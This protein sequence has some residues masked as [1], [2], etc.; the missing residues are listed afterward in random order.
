MK[1]NVPK[2][3]AFAKHLRKD[4]PNAEYKL[5]QGLRG[6]QLAGQHFRRQH[7][8]GPYVTDFTCVKERLVVEVDGFGHVTE[9]KKLRDEKWTEYLQAQEWRVIRFNN[10]DVFEDVENDL[11]AIAGHLSTATEA[12]RING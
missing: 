12:E 3:R 2:T 7:P 8:I 1:D 10:L 5:W 4:L 6:R 9:E 11:E